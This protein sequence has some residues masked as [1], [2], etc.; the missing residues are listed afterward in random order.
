MHEHLCT[1]GLACAAS[2]SLQGHMHASVKMTHVNCDNIVITCQS[3][4]MI[5]QHTWGAVRHVAGT[6]TVIL[7]GGSH[8]ML[9]S[10]NKDNLCMLQTV[11]TW[12]VEPI[13]SNT[14]IYGQHTWPCWLQSK[15]ECGWRCSRYSADINI[16]NGH[17]IATD[18]HALCLNSWPVAF[19]P[20]LTQAQPHTP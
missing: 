12:V 14:C 16:Y 7:G 11:S 8:V 9:L 18:L 17:P 4:T 2:Q 20:V 3:G 6:A 13:A 1:C 5:Q 10:A 15:G 19:L